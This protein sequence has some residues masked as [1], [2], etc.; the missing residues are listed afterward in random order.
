[1]S[2]ALWTIMFHLN[3]YSVNHCDAD[4]FFHGTKA[5]EWS[6]L[7]VQPQVHVLSTF[8]GWLASC[9]ISSLNSKVCSAS[10]RCACNPCICIFKQLSAG[11][12]PIQCTHFWPGSA[13]GCHLWTDGDLMGAP[14]LMKIWLW[15]SMLLKITVIKKIRIHRWSKHASCAYNTSVPARGADGAAREKCM[16][17]QSSRKSQA[18]KEK[19]TFNAA[20]TV[21][22]PTLRDSQGQI[23]HW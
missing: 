1:M 2:E 18:K 22:A 5:P 10:N 13:N 21:E 23:S 3:R 20:Y 12:L 15:R 9:F 17:P 8:W 7:L 11:Q 6:Q 19:E 14:L 4:H 16:F